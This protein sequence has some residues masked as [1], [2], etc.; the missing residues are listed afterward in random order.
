LLV[1]CFAAGYLLAG[2]LSGVHDTT[3]LG[4]ICLRVDYVNGLQKELEGQR[5]A[6]EDVREQFKALVEE[7]RAALASRA[8]END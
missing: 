1:L 4:R 5:A 3:P 6:S 8:A 7:C 2:W